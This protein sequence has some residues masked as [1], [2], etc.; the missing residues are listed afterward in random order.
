MSLIRCSRGRVTGVPFSRNMR[1]GAVVKFLRED[2]G[3]VFALVQ[4]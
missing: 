3:C 1:R 2:P 4:E